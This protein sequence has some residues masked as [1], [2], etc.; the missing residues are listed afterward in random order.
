MALFFAEDENGPADC[1]EVCDVSG[2]ALA[3]DLERGDPLNGIGEFGEKDAH[4]ER[5]EGCLRE[6]A[7]E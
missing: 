4:F 2:T 3:I 1:V 7:C 6:G 5:V